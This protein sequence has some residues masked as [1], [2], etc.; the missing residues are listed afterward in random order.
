MKEGSEIVRPVSRTTNAEPELIFA[1]KDVAVEM[2]RWLEHLMTERRMS[3]KTAEAYE[4]DARQFARA[5]DA[6]YSPDIFR[7]VRLDYTCQ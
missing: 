4:R 6:R 3:G 7:V 1:A 2:A 5:Y